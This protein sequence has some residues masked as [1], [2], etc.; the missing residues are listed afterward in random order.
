MKFHTI[1]IASATLLLMASSSAFSDEL[2]VA[3]DAAAKKGSQAISFDLMSE[4]QAAGIEA[5]VN[6]QAPK[7]AR[8]DVSN[9]AKKVPQSHVAS[10]VYNGKEVVILLYSMKNE[11]LPAGMID[12]GIIQVEG[13]GRSLSK[14]T[15]APVVSKFVA[16][17]ASGDVIDS[18]IHV[19]E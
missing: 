18:K 4:G 15:V 9:C 3:S 5:R 11:N 14:A 8:V 16:A 13:A 10:C 19:A 17:A 2:I 1:L 12:L 6:I 7:G